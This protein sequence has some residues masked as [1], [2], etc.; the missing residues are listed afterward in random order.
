MY[1]CFWEYHCICTCTGKS[2]CGSALYGRSESDRI[3]PDQEDKTVR[4]EGLEEEYDSEYD[5]YELLRRKKAIAE[6]AATL[7]S[8]SD[9]DGHVEKVNMDEDTPDHTSSDSHEGFSNVA[10]MDWRLKRI[11]WMI[12]LMN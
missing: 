1:G 5:E 9:Q 10:G 8:E 11:I 12:S 2:A 4:D 3:Y 6:L 7:D